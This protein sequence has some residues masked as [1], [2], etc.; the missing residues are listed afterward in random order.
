MKAQKTPANCHQ[1]GALGSWQGA[2]FSPETLTSEAWSECCQLPCQGILPEALVQLE[3]TQVDL[4][5]GG[6]AFDVRGA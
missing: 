6:P 1:L 4:E 5:D 2:R 3:R